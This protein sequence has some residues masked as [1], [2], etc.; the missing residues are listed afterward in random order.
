MLKG[1]IGALEL[2]LLASSAQNLNT[3]ARIQ[4]TRMTS[5]RNPVC[6]RRQ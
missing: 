2:P 4:E 5:P 3:D 6:L 1:A